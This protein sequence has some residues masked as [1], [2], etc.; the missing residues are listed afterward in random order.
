MK[1]EW[2]KSRIGIRTNGEYARL[3]NKPF[4]KIINY[5]TGLRCKYRVNNEMYR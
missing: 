1:S 4:N 3:D 2:E 5:L